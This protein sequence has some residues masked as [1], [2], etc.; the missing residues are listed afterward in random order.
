MTKTV[1]PTVTDTMA[2]DIEIALAER[3]A[4][5]ATQSHSHD[6]AWATRRAEQ[7]RKDPVMRDRRLIIGEDA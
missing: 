7:R 2:L 4:G 1:T 3:R 5:R 6:I